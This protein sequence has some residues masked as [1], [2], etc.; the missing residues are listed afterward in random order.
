[1]SY[2]QQGQRTSKHRT[3]AFLAWMLTTAITGLFAAVPA[4][5]HTLGQSYIFANIEEEGISGHLELP[6]DQL[7]PAVGLAPPK[8]T[9]DL[10]ELLN[11]EWP[12]IEAYL[13]D[14]FSIA[15]G[16]TQ[17]VLQFGERDSLEIEVAY[18]L[19]VNFVA[20]APGPIAD[21]VDF[22][23]SAISHAMP[24]HRGGLVVESNVKTGLEGNHRELSFF[25]APGRED[26]ALNT[27]GESALANLLQFVREGIVHIWIGY[28]HIL[29]LVTLLLTSV[30]VGTKGDFEPVD[31]L[32]PA[33]INLI[34]VVTLF[35]VAHSITLALAMKGW[36]TVPSRMVESMI[37][38]SI[39]VVALNNIY[40]F[41]RTHVWL[42]IFGFGLFHGLGFA[43]VLMELA[44][45]RQSRIMGLIGF[46]VGVEIGQLAIVAG[47]FP[48]LYLLR[49]QPWYNLLVLK[50]GSGLIALVGAWWL[51]TRAFN[52]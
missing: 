23:Y 33:L 36:V 11:N 28:D 41:L 45:N 13:R 31:R 5:A 47:L 44:V 26:F 52:L 29:F 51:V 12:R 24:D 27:L 43:S 14:H 38:L 35:T 25:F 39:V 37:A 49:Q 50:A 22:H 32:R 9:A 19:L 7:L 18:F 10:A 46:N 17:Y 3:T 6:A 21:K 40:P 2:P 30:V 15:Q 20:T 4:S 48:I 1:M 42:L 34:T 8:E 16:G